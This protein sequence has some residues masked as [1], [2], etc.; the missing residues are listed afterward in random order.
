MEPSQVF[1]IL[2]ERITNLELPPGS[3]LNLSELAQDFGMSRTPIKEAL[4]LLQ[5]DEWVQRKGS[6]F[7]VTPLSIDR[8]KDITEI[9]AV[10][11]LQANL[12]A[13]ERTNENDLAALGK[14]IIE[15]EKVNDKT[16][17]KRLL[18]IDFKFH[19][20]IYK[21]TK[22]NQIIQILQRLLRHYSRYWLSFQVDVDRDS[23]FNETLDIIQAIHEKNEAKLK[24]ATS[25]HI[26]KSLQAIMG[27]YLDWVSH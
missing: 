18:E 23:C 3:I 7:M 15:I 17:L 10:L 11:E 26:K 14:L 12:W 27:S 5:A 24:T 4:I 20:I 9:R 22:N 8:I 6:H 1:S 19:K 25:E 21:A 16:S 13:M 2:R